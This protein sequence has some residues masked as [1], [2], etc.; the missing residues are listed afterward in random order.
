MKPKTPSVRKQRPVTPKKAKPRPRAV[1]TVWRP[2]VTTAQ[3]SSRDQTQLIA[4]AAIDN[5]FNDDGEVLSREELEKLP[6]EVACTVAAVKRRRGRDGSE[7][8]T[9]R[10]RD[11]AAAYKRLAVETGLIP[12]GKRRRREATSLPK[13]VH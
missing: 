4:H 10:M 3:V 5:F 8:V 6:P 1:T 11:K 2:S 9:V 7:S 12:A 13:R